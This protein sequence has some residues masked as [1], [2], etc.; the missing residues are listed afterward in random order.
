MTRT[1]TTLE[2][3]SSSQ[4]VR[5]GIIATVASEGVVR[6]VFESHTAL[7]EAHNHLPVGQAPVRGG[8]C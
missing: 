7:N 2:N 5:S 8:E 1:V 3:T 6:A 4:H